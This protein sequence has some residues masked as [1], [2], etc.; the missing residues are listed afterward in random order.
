MHLCLLD[1]W[2]YPLPHPAIATGMKPIAARIAMLLWGNSHS[3]CGLSGYFSL[4]CWPGINFPRWRAG[5]KHFCG[6]A[7]ADAAEPSCL[8][9]KCLRLTIHCLTELEQLVHDEFALSGKIGFA[10]LQSLHTLPLSRLHCCCPIC[11]CF[12]CRC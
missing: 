9:A 3:I 8:P 6:Q 12:R 10:S 11:M 1:N 7:A 4:F 2:C 5:R